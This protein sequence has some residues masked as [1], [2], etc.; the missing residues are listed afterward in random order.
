MRHAAFILLVC[1]LACARAAAPAPGSVR[2]ADAVRIDLDTVRDSVFV[3]AQLESRPVTLTCPTLEYPRALR[4]QGVQGRVLIQL[5]I[6]TLGRAEP[7]T[8]RVLDTPDVGL[9]EAAM[10]AARGCIFK[11][12]RVR[13]RAVR[14]KVDVPFDFNL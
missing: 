12:G 1:A 11:P 2:P 6:D 9:S 10:K 5:I 14:V 4:A 7:N 13:G 3:V 8:I